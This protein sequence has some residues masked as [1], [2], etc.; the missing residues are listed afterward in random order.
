MQWTARELKGVDAVYYERVVRHA[1]NGAAQIY[2]GFVA[3]LTAFCEANGVRY[4]EVNVSTIKSHWT[5]KGNA[6]KEAMIERCKERGFE[7]QDDNEADAYALLDYAL[8]REGINNAEK[9]I[10]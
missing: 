7:P 3:C 9:I 1:S 5:G 10:R 6:K 4:V 8:E 2:G